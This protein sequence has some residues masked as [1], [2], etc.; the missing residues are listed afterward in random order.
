MSTT[1]V[2]KSMTLMTFIQVLFYCFQT[3]IKNFF[4]HDSIL[5]DQTNENENHFIILYEH[6]HK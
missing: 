5:M 3:K 2:R 6:H 1:N 4:L